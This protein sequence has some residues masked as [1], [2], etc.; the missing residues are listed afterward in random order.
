MDGC[1]CKVMRKEAMVHRGKC[2]DM[3]RQKNMLAYAFGASEKIHESLI[4]CCQ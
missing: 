2:K 1:R 4:D 3:K